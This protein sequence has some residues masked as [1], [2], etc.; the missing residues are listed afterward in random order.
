MKKAYIGVGSN[1]GNRLQYCEKAIE[2]IRE[3]PGSKLTGNS[4]W[5]IT[6]P[7]GVE[8][9]D[10]YVNGVAE[11]ETTLSAKD[12]LEYLFRIEDDLGRVRERRWDSR[13][14]DLD[15][16]MFGMDKIE[17]E[18]LKVPHPRMHLRR[19]VLI[20]MVQLAPGLTHPDFGLTMSQL[21][22]DLSDEGQTVRRIKG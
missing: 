22:K 21:L 5:Y 20:P 7:V 13:T 19:F 11:V 3:I 8:G 2:R 4:D 12:L 14:I 1:L 18:D 9:Q 17:E 6:E 10:W 16:L 15:L